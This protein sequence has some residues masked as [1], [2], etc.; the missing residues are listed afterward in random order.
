MPRKGGSIGRT[1]R[2]NERYIEHA[3][4]SD[5]V[6]KCENCG[7]LFEQVWRP[8]KGKDGQG[9]YTHFKTCPDCR[10]AN[11]SGVKKV[12]I[13]YTP[14]EAQQ[15]IHNS[16]KRFKIL[17]C[18]PPGEFILGANKPIEDVSTNDYVFGNNRKLNKVYRKIE[19]EY[20]GLLYKINARY[21][22]PF[23]VTEEH[24]ILL[25]KV[26]RND[27]YEAFKKGRRPKKTIWN[28]EES[29]WV[30][31][32]DIEKY[33]AQQTQYI[34]WCLKIPRIKGTNDVDKWKMRKLETRNNHYK[35]SFPIN[36]DT[37]WLLGLFMAEGST[38]HSTVDYG[39][40]AHEKDF[41]ERVTT[42][43]EKLGYSVS[44]G[45][46]KE[47][48]ATSLAICSTALAELFAKEFDTGAS[49]KQI[50]QDI[51][52]HKNR[53]VV[54]NFLRGY[55]DGDGH[56]DEKQLR[57][58]GK[59]ASR[60]L[61][62]QLQLL[63]ARLGY[64]AYIHE[65]TRKEKGVINGRTINNSNPF[66]M[67]VCSSSKLIN[68]LGYSDKTK[69][70]R[71][72]SFIKDDAI[73]V[74]LESVETRKYKG[75]VY[76]LSTNDDTFLV[77]NIVSHNCGNRFGKDLGAIGEGVMK[78]LQM[79]NEERSID[80][81][82]PVLWWI[83]APNMKLA[84]QN[85][86]DL[87]KL[88]PQ[89][90]VYNISIA[91]Y[92]IETINGGIIEVHSA[93]DPETLVGVGLDIVTITEAARIRDLDIVWANLRQRLDSPGR[94]PNGKGGI[95]IINST[96]KGRTYFY[97]M[98][99]M[100]DKTSSLY[101]PE[102]ETFRF[103]TWDNPFMAI[104]RYTI[105]GQD[106]MGNDITFEESIRMSMTENRYRQDYLAE[107]IMEIN[108]VFPHFDKV[109]VRPPSRKED[110]IAKF[111]TEWEKVDPFEVYTIGY[112][113]ASKGDGKPC[114][115][116]NSKGKVVKVDM[117]TRLGWDAQWDKL[118]MYSRLYNGATVNFGQ[119]GLGET[120][121][122]QLTKRGVPNV[123]INEQG[124][125]KSKLVED[126]ALIVEQQWCQIPWSNEM[127][128][129]LQDYVSVDREGRTTQYHNATDSGHDDL[130]SAL[131]FCFSDFQSPALTL[132]WVGL[133]GGIKTN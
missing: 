17:V 68:E 51:L 76:N 42:S 10:M 77:S 1:A 75:K 118:A 29:I 82:P 31:A 101:S 131:Y 107:F 106:A 102:Y 111:W 110:E 127:E 23:E 121:G 57:I 81:N 50:P 113:P 112:D 87:K 41:I 55:F 33:L 67:V 15:K 9:E 48:N 46:K 44:V 108:S 86:R 91:D 60:K 8:S 74:P 5:R 95:A 89:E 22:L 39:L 47:N 16:D 119:T 105:V 62:Y 58:Y 70:I 40:G 54:L 64:S 100:G 21:I 126:L 20:N 11:A 52:L 2:Q 7:K 63:L 116:R 125:N 124:N 130:V 133:I 94:G 120:I 12:T 38:T 3:T 109:L 96:P 34:K 36:E 104:K 14:H 97:K 61:A 13:P 69:H 123:P 85:W 128:K 115:I 49:N 98:S 73:Y 24:P 79:E 37:A 43:Y 83:V 56:F 59:T 88:F 66:Y 65:N 103:T 122:S 35:P 114:I 27:N 4:S 18:L 53:N 132:P 80:V 93:D 19:N 30:K 99:L 72:F 92:T 117:M 129:Q 71:E 28:T 25:T 26:V 6:G 45:E 84:R 90:L 32:C 78:F